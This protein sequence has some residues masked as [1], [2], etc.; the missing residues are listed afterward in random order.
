M[1]TCVRADVW[2]WARVSMLKTLTLE[3]VEHGRARGWVK[4]LCMG[5]DPKNPPLKK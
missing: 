2:A 3:R 1:Y 4:G 5:G